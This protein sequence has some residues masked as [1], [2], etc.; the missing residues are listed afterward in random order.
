MTPLPTKFS[1]LR[2]LTMT[3]LI[4]CVGMLSGCGRADDNSPQ[5]SPAPLGLVLTLNVGSPDGGIIPLDLALSNPGGQAASFNLGGALSTKG[6]GAFDFYVT[7]G[8]DAEVWDLLHGQAALLDLFPVTL[9][10]GQQMTFQ[11]KWDQRDNQG[12]PVQPG[13]YHVFGALYCQTKERTDFELKTET[14]ELQVS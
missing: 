2:V 3:L 1:I 13:T 7:G 9:E 5:P 14:K 8:G 4:V 12:Q 10:A 6:D 11:G